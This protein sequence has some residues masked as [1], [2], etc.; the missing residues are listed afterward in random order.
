MTTGQGKALLAESLALIQTHQESW[1]QGA[2]MDNDGRTTGAPF[3]C[4]AKGCL[5]GW[6]VVFH[7]TARI[8]FDGWGHLNGVVDEG[9]TY[10]NPASWFRDRMGMD[11]DD[12]EEIG[13]AH[14]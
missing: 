14:V 4:D 6:A 13:R 9:S 10:A 2:W 3:S 11:W 12:T 8:E 7:P 5:A 1:K